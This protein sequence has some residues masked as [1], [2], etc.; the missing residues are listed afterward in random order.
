MDDYLPAG[1]GRKLVLVELV[2]IDLELRL[3]AGEAARAEEYLDR[4]PELAGDRSTVL[5]LIAFEYQ[6][7]LREEPGLL[8]ADYLQRFPQYREVLPELAEQATA[9]ANHWPRPPADLPGQAPLEV[10]GYEILEVLGRGGMGVVYKARQGALNRVVALKMILAAQHAGPSA[11]SRFRREAEIVAQ[12]QHPHIVQIYEVGEN[13]GRH[14][15]AMEFIEGGSLDGQLLGTPQPARAAA[16]LVETLARAIHHAHQHDIIHRDLKPAN[17][18]LQTTK[19]SDNKTLA[20]NLWCSVRSKTSVVSFIPKITDFGVAKL[21]GGAEIGPTQSGDMLGTPSYMAPEQAAGRSSAMGPATD[22]YGLGSILYELL[23]GRP[24]FKAETAMETLFQVQF[25]DPVSPSQLQPKLPRDL[26]TICLRCLQKEPRQRYASA[27]ALAEDLRRFLD[28]RPVQA[29]PVSQGEKLWRW[30]R[31]KPLVAA[32]LTSV[33]VLV[34][35]VAVGAPLAAFLWHEQRDEARRNEA[36]AQSAEQDALD[37]LWQSYQTQAELLRST[38]QFGQRF[39]GLELLRKAA[40]IRESPALRNSAIACLALTDLKKFRQWPLRMSVGDLGAFDAPLERYAYAA[41]RLGYIS[42]RSAADDRELVVLTGPETRGWVSEMKFSPDGR[43]LA[44]I[45]NFPGAPPGRAFVWELSQ[46]A[47]M[48][49][50]P[51]DPGECG[52]DFSPDSSRIALAG[53]DG[54]IGI[55]AIAG[56]QELSHLEKSCGP[57]T[58]AFDPTGRRLAVASVEDHLVEIRDLDEGGRVAATFAHP[59]GV[60][61]S[62]WRGDGQLLATG[63]HDKNAYVWDVAA[64]RQLAALTGHK[65]PVPVVAFNPTGDLLATFSWDGTSKLWDPVD[66]ANLLTV[67]GNCFHFDRAGEHLGYV[68]AAGFGIWHV[69]GRRECRTLH[70]GRVGRREPEPDSGGPWSVDFSSDGQLLAAAGRDGVRLWDMPAAR[71]VAHLGVGHSESTW[72][73][74][75]E[76]SLIT[77]GEKGLQRWPMQRDHSGTGDVRLGAPVLLGAP[78]KGS[79]YRAAFS[80][81]GKKIA[82]L[83]FPRKQTIVI[84]A[85]TFEK[86]V[87]LEDLR[88]ESYVAL[89]PNA[90]WVA[91]GNWRDWEAAKVWDLTSSSTTPVWQLANIDSGTGSCRVGF[92]SDGQWLVT[93]EQDKYRFWQVGSWAPGLVIHRDGLEP[94]PGPLAF[95]P[96]KRMLAIAR[97]ALKV[98]LIELATGREIAILSAPDLQD[99]TSLCFSPDSG[100]LAVATDNRTI[101]LWDLRLIQR[102]LEEL[103][104][105][106]DLTMAR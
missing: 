78:T 55:I 37:E 17:I 68:S 74:P 59:S 98:Q 104:L 16:Q 9:I 76:T 81:D 30:C 90:R 43:Y 51:T 54:S 7:R 69:T 60:Y 86:Q 23:T 22:V 87:V 67:H 15:F 84:D 99:I 101:Q 97:S 64:K 11:V 106:G 61:R 41:D 13:D 8:V 75:K 48:L 92:S 57:H 18:L 56:G 79:R 39:K 102:Q 88:R 100:Q 66:G 38:K 42:V 85:K 83:D 77:Y 52:L 24:P 65:S 12:L 10:A 72:F 89:S 53:G 50:K 26:V 49:E 46:G 21:L 35:L 36:R 6:L 2:H 71:E 25:T 80:E 1:D 40:S 91:V 3:K 27:L 33:T 105:H 4:Y 31:R 32:L 28:G 20:G 45:Y 63:C 14:F 95:S 93:S 34:L 82:Y 96:D 73:S 5:E 70:F 62:A 44:A 19:D 29:R 47:T 94:H 58:L 103:N